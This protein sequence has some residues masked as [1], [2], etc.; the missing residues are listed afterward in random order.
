MSA[1]KPKFNLDLATVTGDWPFVPDEISARLVCADDGATL[2]QLR[3]ELGVLQ[4]QLEGRPDGRRYHGHPSV[5]DYIWHE[6]RLGRKVDGG[7]WLELER[8]LNQFNYR[9][10]A[11]ANLSEQALADPKCPH[12]VEFIRRTVDDIDH[13][14]QVIR[15]MSADADAE[16]DG[17]RMAPL[18]FNR[19]RLLSR[20]ACLE[21]R[22]EE[23]VEEIDAGIAAL[24]ETLVRMG[25]DEEVRGQDP[26]MAYLRQMGRRLRD[27]HGIRTTLRERLSDAVARED[28]AEAAQLRD[29]LRRRAGAKA[30]QLPPPDTDSTSPCP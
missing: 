8:E 29:L 27:Q 23:A 20:L 28:F 25:L 19:A 17:Q 30:P 10:L 18:L 6:T 9:R 22:F 15:T 2:L 26:G 3:V 21:G 7:D 12:T 13:C 5:L 16:E 24:E 11:L 14:A 4:M 1:G